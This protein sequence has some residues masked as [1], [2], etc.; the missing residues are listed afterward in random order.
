[1]AKK[2]AQNMA[3]KLGICLEEFSF[4]DCWSKEGPKGWRKDSL[5]EFMKEVC[6]S[7]LGTNT[8]LRWIL[9]YP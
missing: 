7:P 3:D 8:S 2:F 1:M 6:C 9:T 5:Q 4:K